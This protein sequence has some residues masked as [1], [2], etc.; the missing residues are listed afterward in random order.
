MAKRPLKKYRLNSIKD[1]DIKRILKPCEA[2][3]GHGTIIILL[4]YSIIG[5]AL[6][7]IYKFI[8]WLI[9]IASS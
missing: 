6:F 2:R 3:A 7:G 1:P 8:R 9:D 5:G 4:V